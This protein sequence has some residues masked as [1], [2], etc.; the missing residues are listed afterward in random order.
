LHLSSATR[1][2]CCAAIACSSATAQQAPSAQQPREIAPAIRGYRDM[3]RREYSGTRARDVVAYMERWFRVPGNTGFDSSLTNVERILRA[4]GYVEES[5]ATPRDR[6]TYRI[7]TRPLRG[8][9]WDP[10]DAELAIVGDAAPLLRMATNKNMLAINS[11]STPDTG[12]VAELVDVGDGGAR[13]D[14]VHVQGKVVLVRG[15]VGRGFQEAVVKR[16]AAGV[17]SYGMPAYTQ[18]EKNTTSIQ[19]GGIAQDT[20]RKS[21]GMPISRGAYDALTKAL[22]RGPVRVRVRTKTRLFPSTERTLV[23]DVRGSVQPNERF[24]LSA[25]IQEP[26]ANDNASGVGSLAEMARVLAVEVKRGAL[27]P[28]RT[29]TMIFG[30]EVAQ[31]ANY[32]ADTTRARTVRWGMSLDMTGEDVAKT[33]GSFLIE[34]MPD[35]SAVWTRGDDKH[36][37]WGGGDPFP[38]DSL[39][40]HYYND[41]VLDRC[42]DQADGTGWV[43]KTNPF[44]GG[45]DHVPFL[46]ANKPGVLLWHFTDQFYHTDNDRLDKVSAAEQKNSGICALLTALTLTNA[47]AA[48]TQALARQVAKNGMA[49]LD[50]ELALSRQAIAA[51]GDMARERRILQTWAAWYRDAIRAMR[52]VEVGGSTPATAKTLE[53]LSDAIEKAGAAH[54]A[55]LK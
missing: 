25:H 17:L 24:V 10:I 37:E 38:V 8:L 50:R 27:D 14:S 54:T 16:N 1:A 39:K 13:F 46:R 15:G 31:T 11:F 28:K 5:R 51:G 6:L 52:D 7:E 53:A 20:V 2:L 49:R 35:P 3:A 48:T 42:L 30:N 18:P 9:A 45:S 32:L 55:Q 29:I 22:A 40:P 21:W 26:G 36:T 4:A 47:D 33:G 43:V 41:V 44:E 23:A 12:I 19:F 34:K